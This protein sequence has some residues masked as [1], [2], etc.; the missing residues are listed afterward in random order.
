MDNV[1]RKRWHVCG[2]FYLNK[3]IFNVDYIKYTVV[4]SHEFVQCNTI[5]QQNMD[6]HSCDTTELVYSVSTIQ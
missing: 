5:I 3:L 6:Y 2:I 1:C 4:P